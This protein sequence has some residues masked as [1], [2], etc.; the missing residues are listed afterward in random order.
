MCYLSIDIILLKGSL[1]T[2]AKG[3]GAG[4]GLVFRT[5]SVQKEKGALAYAAR[6]FSILPCNIFNATLLWKK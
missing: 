6:I 4:V 2:F 3:R 5:T 1:V